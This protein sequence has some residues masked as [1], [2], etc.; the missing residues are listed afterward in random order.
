MIEK[1]DFDLFV[2]KGWN[3]I[4]NVVIFFFLWQASSTSKIEDWNKINGCF[5]PHTLKYQHNSVQTTLLLKVSIIRL[6]TMLQLS[7]HWIYKNWGFRILLTTV[8]Y[9]NSGFYINL[10]WMKKILIQI[11]SWRLVIPNFANWDFKESPFLRGKNL[12][13]LKQSLLLFAYHNVD[14][15]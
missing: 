1:I 2:D 14:L 9:F 13:F 12:F 8:M 15:K 7:Q 11:I 6:K 5:E 10:S 4:Y 3:T